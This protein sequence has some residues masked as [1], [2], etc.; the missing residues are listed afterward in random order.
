MDAPAS[1]CCVTGFSSDETT[2]RHHRKCDRAVERTVPQQIRW[3]LILSLRIAAGSGL[4]SSRSP[5]DHD[6]MSPLPGGSSYGRQGPNMTR[7]LAESVELSCRGAVA[8]P[9][10]GSASNPAEEIGGGEC[11][12]G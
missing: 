12:C 4:I 8:P 5:S 11:L 1:P 7:R 10:T 9:V 6:S 3:R 2:H